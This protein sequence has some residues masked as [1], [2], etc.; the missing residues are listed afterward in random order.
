MPDRADHNA[1]ALHTIQNDV[2]SASDHELADPRL[3]PD[4]AQVGMISESFDHGN[5]PYG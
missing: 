5:N 3:G 2:R 1:P 4:A